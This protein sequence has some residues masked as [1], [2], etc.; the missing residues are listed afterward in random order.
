MLLSATEQRDRAWV[1]KYQKQK[2]PE[3]ERKDSLALL[4]QNLF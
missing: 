4:K 3:E 2:S 1:E